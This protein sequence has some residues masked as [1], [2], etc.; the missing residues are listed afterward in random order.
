M[1]RRLSAS[2]DTS[3][4]GQSTPAITVNVRCI[5]TL[6]LLAFAVATPRVVPGATWSAKMC[7][8]VSMAHSGTGLDRART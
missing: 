8:H 7:G 4:F 6:L 2:R 1:Q 5:S 3:R